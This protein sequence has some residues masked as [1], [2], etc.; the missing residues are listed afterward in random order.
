MDALQGLPP[1]KLH[2]PFKPQIPSSPALLAYSLDKALGEA[3]RIRLGAHR[4]VEVTSSSG[5]GQEDLVVPRL[6]SPDP[7]PVELG[8]HQVAEIIDERITV[9][10]F[11]SNLVGRICQVR[12]EMTA[13]PM[14][15]Y[16]GL[17][18][19]FMFGDFD[20]H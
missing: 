17:G 14:F 4:K 9:F 13:G 12:E 3:C 6:T 5:K 18:A 16:G 15:I 1:F 7:D 10:D 19:D 8:T 20:T 2:L 11:V